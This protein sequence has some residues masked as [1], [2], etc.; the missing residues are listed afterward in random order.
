MFGIAAFLFL[1]V[2]LSIQ[3]I[4]PYLGQ[5][6][7]RLVPLIII[8]PIIGLML[9]KSARV[10]KFVVYFCVTLAYAFGVFIIFHS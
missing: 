7:S 10:V 6:A 1:L 5:T 3:D 8:L 9:V 4:T 2:E